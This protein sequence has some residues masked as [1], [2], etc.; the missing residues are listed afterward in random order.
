MMTRSKEQSAPLVSVVLISFN[1]EK[2]IEKQVRSILEQSYQNIELIISDD[3]SSD[4]TLE[5]LEQFKCDPRLR[6]ISNNGPSGIHGNLTNGLRSAGGSYIAISDQD[7]IWLSEKIETLMNGIRDCS[8]IFSDSALID[9]EDVEIYP[10][11]IAKITRKPISIGR[12]Y[13]KILIDNCVSGHALLFHREL[14]DCIIPFRDIPMYDQQVALVA[15][16]YRGLNFE[17]RRLVLHRQHSENSTNRLIKSKRLSKADNKRIVSARR[18]IAVL[19]ASISIVRHAGERQAT[20][21]MLDASRNF[22][23]VRRLDNYLSSEHVSGRLSCSAGNRRI[24]IRLF[25]LLLPF[26]K[27]V[28]YFRRN[29]SPWLR[30]LIKLCRY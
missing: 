17:S 30:A 18:R 26:R 4:K 10:S 24:D 12:C 11:L 22:S 3:G 15:T 8:A 21:N 1:G 13:A 7:D 20:T 23:A 19:R 27:Y 9:P 5:K 6:V 28:R 2:Y 25:F 29:S 16:M 14:L